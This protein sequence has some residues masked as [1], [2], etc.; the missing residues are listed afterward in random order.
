V[1]KSHW[2]RSSNSGKQWTFNPSETG[3]Y[4]PASPISVS[5]TLLVIWILFIDMPTEQWRRD[6]PE[7]IRA[8]RR[9]WY[10]KNREHAKAKVI[11]RREDL[12]EWIAG[13]KKTLKCPCGQDHIAVLTFHHNDPSKKD[14]A[15]S[16]A[17]ADG[18][19]KKSILSEIEKCTVLC[20]NCHAILHWKERQ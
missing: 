11:E 13:L 1:D 19:S 10:A 9:R 7:K 4:R 5:K 6:N 14:I 3:Q 16:R 12:R 2:G 17:I 18:W 8:A 20:F 15:I